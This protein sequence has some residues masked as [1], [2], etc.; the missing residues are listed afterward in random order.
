[1]VDKYEI[2]IFDLNNCIVDVEQYHYQAWLATLRNIYGSNFN[3]SFDYFCEKFH[4]KNHDSIENYLTQVL[5]LENL[6]LKD[7]MKQKNDIYIKLIK[8]NKIELIN[9]FDKFI[10]NLSKNNK[11]F[12]IVSDTFKDNIDYFI[13]L[14][15][16][17]KNAD[18]FYYRE[19]FNS[20]KLTKDNYLSIIDHYKNFKICYFT[21]YIIVIDSLFDCSIKLIYLNNNNHDIYYDSIIN[22]YNIQCI[23]DY[24]VLD[25]VYFE[26]KI[27]NTLRLLSVDMVNKANSGHPGMPLGC[28]PTIYVLFCKIMNFNPKDPLM[29][30]RDRFILS[31][32]HGCALLYSI[33]YLLNYN[34]TIDDLKNFR[35]INSITH[36]HP[37]YNPKLGIEVST[38]PLGQ[39]IAN[40][41]GMAIASKKLGLKNKIYVMCGDGCLMEGISYESCSLAGHLE[42][43]NLI[44][45]YDDNKITIDG[46]T[47]LTFTEDIK[48]RFKSQKWNVLEVLNGDTNINDI[49]N[50]LKSKID[51]P[52]IIII[53]TTI[54]YGSL[55]SGTSSCHGTPLGEKLTIELKKFLGADPNKTF[56]VDNDVKRYFN[57]ISNNKTSNKIFY[58]K[59]NEIQLFDNIKLNENKNYATRELS[60]FCLNEIADKIDNV[61]IGCADLTE[62]TKMNINSDYISQNN[63]NG[64]FLHFGIREHSMCGI[65]NGIA[66]YDFIPIVGTFLVFIN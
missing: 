53:K 45:L 11:K 62:S 35:Q 27:I 31:N 51:K 36:G 24:D 49:E 16:I 29:F 28:A 52:T 44:L 14:F 23:K 61:I 21:Y 57:K 17:L 34:Y 55:N 5:K 58:K 64:K 59:N 22:K 26:N 54:G 20:N 65:A 41:V 18:N 60:N 63:F 3:F 38:G 30:D 39:G 32:G 6:I 50:K 47:N 8:N 46:N 25:K 66:T 2:F 43:D 56:Y 48:K 12:V 9:G 37:E 19:K 13:N 4:P 7:I 1:M 15:P 40:G 10:D 42:L 33:L